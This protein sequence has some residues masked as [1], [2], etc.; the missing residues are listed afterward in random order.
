MEE[1]YQIK[2]NEANE[3]ENY[4]Q[5]FDKNYKE[6]E[7]FNKST[8]IINYMRDINTSMMNKRHYKLYNV[9]ANLSDTQIKKEII[10]DLVANVNKAIKEDINNDGWQV[11]YLYKELLQTLVGEKVG[12]NYFRGQSDDLPLL[13]GLLRDGVS[14]EYKND[15]ESNYHKLSYEFPDMLDY[16]ATNDKSKLHERECGLSLLQHYGFKTGLLDITKNPYIALL[17]MLKDSIK[18]YSEPTLYLFN[19]NDHDMKGSSL[20]SEVRKSHINE[21]ILAQ[22]GAFLNFE[23]VWYKNISLEK[24]PCIKIVLRF[25]ENLFIDYLIGDRK[26]IKDIF[27]ENPIIKSEF[28]E[29][30]LKNNETNIGLIKSN[31]LRAINKEISKKLKEYYYIKEDMFPDFENKLKY[32]SNKYNKD[33]MKYSNQEQS[34]DNQ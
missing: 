25:N 9:E 20:F 22:K 8:I 32:L 4:F 1:N 11:F 10:E 7:Y 31:C 12:Y 17:F 13:P 24:I 21:R 2:S 19:I 5:Y 28:Y 30:I 15:F 29:R 26:G 6:D 33:D 3:E 14:D 23:K 27:S 34:K 18:D 16:V